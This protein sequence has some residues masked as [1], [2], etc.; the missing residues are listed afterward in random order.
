MGWTIV[1]S[2]VILII[3]IK[4]LKA[5]LCV[6]RTHLRVRL[7]K[8]GMGRD[9]HRRSEM[10]G[11]IHTLQCPAFRWFWLPLP[12]LWD[13]RVGNSKKV[14]IYNRVWCS[15][16]IIHAYKWTSTVTCT[17]NN[18]HAYLWIEIDMVCIGNSLVC[19]KRGRSGN[20]FSCRKF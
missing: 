1:P 19:S 4:K 18:L 20:F 10:L 9:I 12:F 15:K 17:N 14:K 7:P 6:K 13:G 2:V 8:C 11:Q 16:L 5:S 3:G